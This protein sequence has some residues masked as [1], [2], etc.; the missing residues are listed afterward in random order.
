MSK[1]LL[2]W[3]LII[4]GEGAYHRENGWTIKNTELRN[5]LVAWYGW[6]DEY[7]PHSSWAYLNIKIQI[8]IV[9]I[10]HVH[11]CSPSHLSGISDDCQFFFFFFIYLLSYFL[12]S[13]EDST[14]TNSEIHLSNNC[15]VLGISRYSNIN[16]NGNS[17]NDNTYEIDWI[18]V[19]H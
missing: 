14:P 2:L 19:V 11:T 12:F 16:L 18:I 8:L 5:L 4:I 7:A 15:K 3:T 17:Y 13:D 9:C 10:V 1:E 6:I